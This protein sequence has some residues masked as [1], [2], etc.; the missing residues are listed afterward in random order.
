MLHRKRLNMIYSFCTFTWM[1]FCPNRRASINVSVEHQG[2]TISFAIIVVSLRFVFLFLTALINIFDLRNAYIL[3]HWAWIL[4]RGALMAQCSLVLRC[5]QG[6]AG[7]RSRP[8]VLIHCSYS[9][10]MG[11]S[12]RSIHQHRTRTELVSTARKKCM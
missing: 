1:Q 4:A 5:S 6:S 11:R 10:C 7:C 9:T 12:W 3:F 8:I 2:H